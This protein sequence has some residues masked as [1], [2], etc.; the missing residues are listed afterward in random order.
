MTVSTQV[1]RSDYTGDGASTAFTAQF[2]FIQNSDLV[3]TV[4][5]ATKT[6]GSDYVV[7]GAGNTSG[8]VTFV[9]AP[10]NGSKV[11]IR[12]SPPITQTSAFQNNQTLIESTV[13]NALDKLTIIVQGLYSTISSALTANTL[14]NT[15]TWLGQGREITNIANG[16]ANNSAAT[17]GQLS[18]TI[19]ASGNVPAPGG[20][21]AGKWL[22]ATGASAWAWSALT[23]ATEAVV[24]AV[25]LATAA[26]TAAL[27]INTK[28]VH[29]LGLKS[30]IAGK[31]TIYVP[32]GAMTAGLTNGATTNSAELTTN[33]FVAGSLAF[34][35]ATKQYAYF[36]VAMPKSW[37]GGA[38][39]AQFYWYGTT[40]SGTVIWNLE[41]TAI[42][43]NTP[44][45]VAFSGAG[46][47]TD[48]YINASYMMLSPNTGNIA[49]QGT[50]AGQN[51]VQFRV[52]RDA[53]TDTDTAI[54][55]LLGALITY[56]TTAGTDN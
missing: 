37:D 12:N 16:T 35:G 46:V 45:D 41:A 25:Q 50:P 23:T 26:E 42:P 48:T 7:S 2:M 1:V 43:D 6:L 34:D 20:S 40:G 14:I 51:L 29:P 56:S 47:A 4:D 10:A 39:Q 33:K 30:A 8:T 5:G 11:V 53:A 24:G 31:Q 13:G 9:A 44:L 27:A 19:A 17:V 15:P 32:A 38:L 49:V 28:A 3:V 52:S 22:Q 36:S 55:Y 21:W 54:K 18:A